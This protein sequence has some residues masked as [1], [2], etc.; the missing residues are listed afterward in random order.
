MPEHCLYGFGSP[1]I[2]RGLSAQCKLYPG[3][4]L[5]VL[6]IFAS[7]PQKLAAYYR[8]LVFFCK[9]IS[10]ERHVVPTGMSVSELTILIEYHLKN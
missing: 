5:D 2:Y 8:V 10:V 7:L 1:L 4:P 9:I 3:D 6:P